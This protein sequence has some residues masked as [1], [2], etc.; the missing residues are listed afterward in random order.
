MMVDNRKMVMYQLAIKTLD[1][2]IATSDAGEDVSLILRQYDDLIDCWELDLPKAYLRRDDT[3]HWGTDS[4][5]FD[6]RDSAGTIVDFLGR[7]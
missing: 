2:M 1:L 6:L 4:A 3:S 5:K 7:A